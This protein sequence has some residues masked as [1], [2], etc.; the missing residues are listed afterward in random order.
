MTNL[1]SFL[2]K[3]DW[4]YLS[5]I[6]FTIAF[7]LSESLISISIGLILITAFIGFK[8]SRIQEWKKKHN[9]HFI[10]GI[11]L[12]YLISCLFCADWH[13]GLY[14]LR[15]ALAYL[16]VPLA[17]TFGNTISVKR[18]KTI[19][20]FFVIAVVVSS[21]ITLISYLFS[22]HAVLSFQKAG[23]IHHIRFGIQL[24]LALIVALVLYYS[25]FKRLTTFEKVFY[26]FIM[27]FLLIIMFVNQSITGLVMLGGLSLAGLMMFARHLKRKW[28]RLVLAGVLILFIGSP[29]LYIMNVV[30]RFYDVQQ[31]NVEALDK[32]TELGNPY[33]HDFKNMFLENGNYVG[34]YICEDELKDSWNKRSEKYKIDDISENGYPIRETLKRY[35]TSKGL[36]KDAEGVNALSEE[37]IA[38]I[39]KGIANYIF[40]DKKFSIY[41]RIYVSI[42]ELDRYLKTGDANNQSISQRF[43]YTKAALHIIKRNFWFGVGTGNWKKAYYDA[44]VAIGSKMSPDRYGDAHNQYLNYMVKFGIIGLLL[45]LFL[46]VYPVIKSKKYKNPIILLFLIAMVLSN[47]G[48]SNLETHVGGTLFVFFYCLFLSSEEWIIFQKKE[49][50]R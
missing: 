23:F 16:I 36:R 44:Y 3:T 37:D 27:I 39:T 40:A 26:I 6:L 47:F 9:I 21:A 41:P 46:I 34:L 18:L 10:I 1:I 49:L 11:Y 15:K 33:H 48:D 30:D 20:V 5:L 28:H 50:S 13:W 38:N 24:N 7:P 22:D 2:K 35:L 31:V 45:I 43:E 29:V 4:F 17:F 12:I 8:R 32:R 25:G 42:W 14:D 19:L